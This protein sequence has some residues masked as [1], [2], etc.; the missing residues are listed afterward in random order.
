MGR[1]LGIRNSTEALFVIGLAFYWPVF[2]DIFFQS[3]AVV[4]EKP[5]FDQNFFY[6][7]YLVFVCVLFVVAIALGQGKTAPYI[8]QPK[9]TVFVCVLS[10]LLVILDAVVTGVAGTGSIAIKTGMALLFASSFLLLTDFWLY[11]ASR[12][13]TTRL[14]AL[15]SLSFF[16]SFVVSFTSFFPE[17][18]SLALP[19]FSWT[20]SGVAAWRFARVLDNGLEPCADA[21]DPVPPFPPAKLV[22]LL[23]LF[24]LAGAVVRGLSKSGDIMDERAYEAVVSCSI[25]FVL[26]LLVALLLRSEKSRQVPLIMVFAVFA[27]LFFLGLLIA[28]NAGL[29]DIGGGIVVVGRTF[30]TFFLWL[31]LA[32]RSSVQENGRIR[33]DG[34]IVFV[35][36]EVLSGFLSYSVVPGMV[37]ATGATFLDYSIAFSLVSCFILLA[38]TVAVLASF[39]ARPSQQAA[40]APHAADARPDVCDALKQSHAL[41]QREADVLYHLSLGHSIKHIADEMILSTGTVQSHAKSLYKKLGVHS[42]QEVIDLV[43]KLVEKDSDL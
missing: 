34:L 1:L 21:I 23:V 15:S 32:C 7:L 11:T 35:L 41:T 19:V 24:L 13:Q 31:V 17:P 6:L 25:S 22:P 4:V 9:L 43:D 29:A 30:L 26:S 36:V 18:F 16:L 28:S 42:K 39:A 2:R 5:V 37:E 8:H 12:M 27:M 10:S 40:T 33:P 20:V 38:S 3:S 14:L